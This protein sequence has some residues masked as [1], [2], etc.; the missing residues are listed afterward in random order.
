MFRSK[1]FACL[2][3]RSVDYIKFLPGRAAQCRAYVHSIGFFIFPV[4]EA[5][6]T[7][8]GKRRVRVARVQTEE[9]WTKRGKRGTT[10]SSQTSSHPNSVHLDDATTLWGLECLQADLCGS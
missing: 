6:I 7:Q 9:G 3:M 1:S 4:P 5:S 2:G 10:A 8:G